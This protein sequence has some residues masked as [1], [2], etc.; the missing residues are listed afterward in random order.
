M[1]QP[2]QTLEQLENEY[3]G[4]PDYP[5]YLV[6]TCHRLRKKPLKDFTVED[7]RIMIGQN[8]SLRYLVPLALE[9]LDQNILAEGEY[10]PGDLLQNV[11]NSDPSYW[12]DN[13]E[14]HHRLVLLFHKR[15][16]EMEQLDGVRIS[17]ND[18]QK[19]I[20]SFERFKSMGGI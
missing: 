1:Q 4:D 6:T 19:F 3:W 20:D 13:P 9:K 14:Q 11:L 5:S 18:L 12:V 7:L 10:Y 16:T 2:G 17:K 8:F 15:L